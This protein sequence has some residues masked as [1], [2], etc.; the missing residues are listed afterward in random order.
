MNKGGFLDKITNITFW[1]VS[2][3]KTDDYSNGDRD[4]FRYGI[5]S[6]LYSLKLYLD[7]GSV[8]YILLNIK[9]YLIKGISTF[10]YFI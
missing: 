2:S 10:F 5:T 1:G 9:N 7:Y 3:I 6:R 8:Y 4:I